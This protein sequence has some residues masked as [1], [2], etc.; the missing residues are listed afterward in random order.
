MWRTPFARSIQTAAPRAGVL[1]ACTATLALGCSTLLT[2]A[3][4]MAADALIADG[5]TF[6]NPSAGFVSSAVKDFIFPTVKDADGNS[7]WGSPAEIDAEALWTPEQILDITGSAERGA[8]EMLKAIDRQAMANAQA[9]DPAKPI[10]VFG[11][12]QSAVSTM[13][14]KAELAKR[15]QG[16]E[17]IPNVV[18]VGIGVGNRPNGG[19][20]MRLNGI[21]IP[22]FHFAF[23]GAAPTDSG[24]TTIDIVRQ[25]DGLADFPQFPINVVALANALIGVVTVHAM[26]G[27]E[28]S[29]DPQSP[30]Y[31]PGTKVEV[32]GDTTYYTIPTKDLPLL[33]PLR[34]V[35]VPESVLDIVEPTLRVIVEAGYDRTVSAGIPTPAQLIPVLDPATFTL[36]LAQGVLDGA[37]NA[38][39]IIGAEL[40]GYED[41]TSQLT[42]MEGQSAE[43]IGGPYGDVVRD[44]NANVNPFTAFADVEGPIADAFDR[45][46]IDLGV[47]WALN[48]VIDPVLFPATGYLEDK[49]LFPSEPPNLLEAAVIKVLQ[50]IAPSI[51]D[52]IPRDEVVKLANSESRGLVSALQGA[53][54]AD[55]QS[56]AGQ[57]RV[58]GREA[59]TERLRRAL[60]QLGPSRKAAATADVPQA[61]SQGRAAEPEQTGAGKLVNPGGKTGPANQL[62]R[63]SAL[64]RPESP[65]PIAST[66]SRNR[67]AAKINQSVNTIHTGATNGRTS[68]TTGHYRA[69][70]ATRA[71]SKGGSTSTESSDGG[72]AGKDRSSRNISHK[73]AKRSASTGQPK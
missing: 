33:D 39:A 22:F 1:G 56:D 23:N 8:D 70:A 19:I 15:R 47:Q 13:L 38:F 14:A 59:L 30:K 11:Y 68:T 6:P 65:S 67:L 20:A 21:T 64:T 28:V 50:Q 17:D 58:A 72:Q 57:Q 45:V 27:E 40:P 73:P 9:G 69:G 42:A 61:S 36:Q 49:I 34:L 44:I 5:T 16:G 26:Y 10:V 71:P 54:D 51:G 52:Q 29:L 3:P 53:T 2:A 48:K 35:G 12:S 46:L 7:Q 62:M 32:V 37:N 55:P 25:Y 18:F 41:L 24:I 43:T 63:P 66:S 31:V 60:S 4:S